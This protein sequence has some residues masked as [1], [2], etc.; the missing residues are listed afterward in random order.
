M[1]NITAGTWVLDPTHTEIGFAVRHIMSKVRGKFETFEGALVTAEDITASTV[2]VSVDLSSINTGTADRDN[3]L[4]SGDFFNV[5]T[6]PTMT[7]ATTGVV[8][9][10]DTDFVVTGDLKI[11]D[12]TK[13]IDLAVEF[14]GEGQD[15]W[16]G[17][18]VGVEA[19]AV[20]SRKDWGIDFNIPLEGDKVM[21]GDKITITINAEAALQ[22]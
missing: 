21:I 2:S 19:S 16:G 8:Q 18:R 22:A 10:S 3:H 20:I 12:I 7:F 1:S 17:T 15:P 14:L 9:K 4:R 11:K 5:E 13:S 6:N